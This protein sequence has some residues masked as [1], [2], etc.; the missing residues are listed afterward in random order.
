[1]VI[2]KWPQVNQ[3]LFKHSLYLRIKFY[4]FE[5]TIL[6]FEILATL[7]NHQRIVIYI[8]D[9]FHFLNHQTSNSKVLQMIF[10]AK[11]V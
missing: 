10:L 2:V 11:S 7:C 1:M 5:E 8:K 6:A 3:K 9:L 4:D